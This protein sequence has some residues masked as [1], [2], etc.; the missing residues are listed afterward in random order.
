MDNDPSLEQ[1]TTNITAPINRT[2]LTN[3][4]N[5]RNLI[6]LYNNL[7]DTIKATETRLKL[8]LPPIYI[9]LKIIMPKRL[10]KNTQQIKQ[11][12]ILTKHHT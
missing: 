1:E 7:T 3:N 5:K 8:D 9:K 4:N 2:N 6:K 10:E 12:K 11:H